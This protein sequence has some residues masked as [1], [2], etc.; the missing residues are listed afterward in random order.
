MVIVVSDDWAY[1]VKRGSFLKLLQFK[2]KTKTW[3]QPAF[4]SG[5]AKFRLKLVHSV[6]GLP[7]FVYSLEIS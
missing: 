2:N 4:M 7:R 3:K 6:F 5:E 1:L